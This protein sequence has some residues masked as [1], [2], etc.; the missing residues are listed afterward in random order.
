MAVMIALVYLIADQSFKTNLLRASNDDLRAIQKAYA[1]AEPGHGI[2]EATKMIEDRTL[3][4]DSEDRFLLQLGARKIAGNMPVMLRKAGIFY[5]RLPQSAAMREVLGHG[6]FIAPNLY[7]FVGRDLYEVHRSEREILLIFAGVLAASIVLAVASGMWLSGRYLRRIDVI[8]NTCRAIMAGH[9][10]DRIPTQ[11]VNGE[12]ERLSATINGMLDRIQSLMESL[13]QVS[14]DIAHD[15]RTP[16]AHLRYGLEKSLAEAGT[17]QDYE[18]A[19]QQAITEADQL[20]DMFAALLRIARIES[21]ARR[22]AFQTFD[23]SDVLAQAFAMYKPLMEDAGHPVSVEATP[24]TMVEG[25]R[26]LIMQLIANLLD[27]AIHH[28]P[29]GTHIT[30]WAGMEGG[31]PSFVIADTGPGIPQAE[32][33]HVFRRFIRL[34]KSR[35]SSGHGLGLSM[36]S[37]IADLHECRVVLSDNGPGLK[38]SVQFP[39]TASMK[40]RN[41]AAAA[42]AFCPTQD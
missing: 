14:N 31:N 10:N 32:R 36:V 19:A 27:N 33:E 9:L 7:A 21:G 15:L 20:L 8:S 25:D 16:L 41:F 29:A 38:V 4:S 40:Q 26:Q 34:E 22:E 23:L 1:I 39:P 2:H 28:T 11:G 6:E 17:K 5:M 24:G 37:A 3:A 18:R 12:L 35:T 30:G 42:R 13:R